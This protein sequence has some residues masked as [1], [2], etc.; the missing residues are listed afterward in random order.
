MDEQINNSQEEKSR[1]ANIK[2]RY[3]ALVNKWSNV[4]HPN[5]TLLKLLP[6]FVLLLATTLTLGLV[7]KQQNI[8]Q[9]AAAIP[10]QGIFQNKEAYGAGIGMDS[11]NNTQIGG[12]YSQSSSYR[13]KAI[14]T[15]SLNKIHIYIV[16][17][18]HAGYGAGT[19][20]T[21]E[22]T[23]QT[24]DETPNHAPSGT[25]LST[26]TFAPGD[27][28]ITVTFSNP[29]SLTAGNLYH[30]VF[31]NIDSNPTVNYASLD[32]IFMYQPTSPRQPLIS[33][34]NWGQPI[35]NG[36]G[37]WKDRDN[38]VPILQL[39]Y[40][41][42]TTDGIGY[43]EVWVRSYKSIS[44]NSIAREA[45]T[46]S[47]T[48]KNVSSVNL[49]LM[50]INGTSPLKVR[51]E[52]STGTL[53]EEGNIDSTQIPIG[54][55]GDHSGTGHA[56]WATYNFVSTH[57]LKVGQ[58]YNIVLSTAADTTYSIF[59]IRKGV[60][61]QY[62]KSTYF[63]DGHAQYNSGTGWAAFTQDGATALD[64]GDLQFY[65]MTSAQT[66]TLNATAT[67]TPATTL[68]TNTPTPTLKPTVTSVPTNTPTA[69]PTPKPTLTP[70][71]TPVAF[72][73]TSGPI[74][75]A[76][77][78]TQT[79]VTWYLSD[80]G[81]GQVQYGLTSQYGLISATETTFNWNYHIQT[82][83]S[84]TSGTTYHYR[85]KSTNKSGAT[86]YSSDKTFTTTGGIIPTLTPTLAPTIIPTL[87]PT[88]T[89]TP[90]KHCVKVWRW[91]WCY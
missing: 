40:S 65:F 78:N 61:Y 52:T 57:S 53:I 12:Q 3:D 44:G 77:S 51:L 56:T 10:I 8:E 22:A 1:Q 67:P 68:P 34:T 89:P 28:L 39:D 90:V 27:G 42:G 7:Q 50:R 81:T 48:D 35:K 69:T 82:L 29:A 33:D 76:I 71:P 75:S 36:T 30:I 85:V 21:F 13:F 26:T 74:V 19:G 64:E 62:A 43:M 16:G 4:S 14:T 46:V 2:K 66:S 9:D 37:A 32:G 70:T 83:S 38:T 87:T 5:R 59:V 17:A 58:S 80:Y 63:S 91:Q 31:R 20:G 15:S 45:F 60:D 11:L 25:V 86:I 88:P 55:P 73:I 41:D 84:L 18:S 72:Y 54:T 24:D 79:I 47:G 23:V 49:R 6:V